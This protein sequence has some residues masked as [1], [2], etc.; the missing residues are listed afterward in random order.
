M[1]SPPV[2]APSRPTGPSGTS[3]ENTRGWELR[4]QAL[5][6]HGLARDRRARGRRAEFLGYWRDAAL[7]APW[8]WVRESEP[9]LQYAASAPA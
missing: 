9:A 4:L 3:L 5:S 7:N 2:T 6:N 1:P 8:P